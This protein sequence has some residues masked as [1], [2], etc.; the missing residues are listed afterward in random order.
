MPFFRKQANPEHRSCRIAFTRHK[1][2]AHALIATRQLL[3]ERAL[4]V[5]ELAL[6]AAS[7]PVATVPRLGGLE[8]CIPLRTVAPTF[9]TLD[10]VAGVGVIFIAPPLND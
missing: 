5:E 3:R 9:K 7:T 10:M 1:P 8:L 2:R 6:R 4:I